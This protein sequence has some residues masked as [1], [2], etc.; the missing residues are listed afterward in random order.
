MAANEASEGGSEH[1]IRVSRSCVCEL[2]VPCAPPPPCHRPHMSAAVF[3]SLQ[4][5]KGRKLRLPCI[6]MWGFDGECG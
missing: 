5:E 4:D 1:V 2:S 3:N 6:I